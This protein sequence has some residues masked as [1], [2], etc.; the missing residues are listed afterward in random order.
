MPLDSLYGI[1]PPIFG[2][3]PIPCGRGD[4]GRQDNCR[5]KSALVKGMACSRAISTSVE[6]AM[7]IYIYGDASARAELFG[8]VTTAGTSPQL[9]NPASDTN[10]GVVSVIYAGYAPVLLAPGQVVRRGQFLEPIAVGANQGYF[11]VSAAGRG[12]V[13]AREDCDNSGGTEAVWVGA[14]LFPGG[15]TGGVLGAAVASSTNLTNTTTETVFST[16]SVSIP[17]NSLKVGQVL[18]LRAKARTPNTNGTDTFQLRARLGGAG[19]TS[20]G[21]TPALDVAD[22]NLAVLDLTITVRSIGASGR[23]S[24]AGIG[25]VA[26]SL[27]VTGGVG[28]IAIDTT[29]ANTFDITGKWSQANAGDVAVLEDYTLETLN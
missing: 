2:A 9:S 18:H 25:G 28:A 3:E 10:S 16:G 19:G 17:A 26:T 6:T 7:D 1:T 21:L 8:V 5:P 15:T 20:L 24:V 23:I 27:Q 14:D 29:V 12:F 4:Y 22:D 11:R 13:K